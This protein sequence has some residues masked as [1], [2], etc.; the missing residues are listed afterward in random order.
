VPAKSKAQQRFMGM[1]HAYKKGELKGSEASQAIKDAAKG[2]KKKSAKDYASTKHKG[3]PKK[4]KNEIDFGK[5]LQKNVDKYNKRAKKS[6][7]SM[8][9]HADISAL[10]KELSKL[11]KRWVGAQEKMKSAAKRGD[12]KMAN[13]WKGT[14]KK[15]VTNMDKVQDK[16]NAA[17]KKESVSEVF[18]IQYKKD[19]RYLT[20]KELFDKIPQKFDTEKDAK[21]MLSGLD[22]QYRGNYKI[23]KV[24]ESVNEAKLTDDTLA[25]RIKHWAGQHKGTGVGYGHVLGSLAI[26]MK[27]MGWDKSFKEVVK[28]AKELSKKKKVESVNEGKW[29]KIMTSVRKGS[30]AGP[31]SI[32]VYD[33]AKRKVIHNRIVKILQQIPAH[34]EDVKK[35]YPRASIGIE[36]KY[37]HRVYTE[38][39]NEGFTK[40]HI[41]LTN[42]RGWYGVWD[43]NGKQ[44]FEG[45]RRYVTRQLKK[46]KT[47]MGNVQLKSLID[48]ATKRKGKNIEFDVV[49]SVDEGLGDN[50]L[51]NLKKYKKRAGKNKAAMDAARK[52][53]KKESVGEGT[54]G[55]THTVDGKKLK[56]PGGTDDDISEA[57]KMNVKLL[58]VNAKH[59]ARDVMDFYKELR[60]PDTE[61]ESIIQQLDYLKDK[62]KM[63]RKN[64]GLK[65][66]VNE[67][68]KLDL[69]KLYNKALKL[70]AKSPVQMKVR[71][72]IATLRKKIGMDE[73][74]ESG[75]DIARRVVKNKQ[76]EKGLDLTTANFIIQTYKAYNKNPRLQKKLDKMPLLKMVKLA[77][78]VMK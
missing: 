36:D 37:G 45:D 22:Y 44:K 24:K 55:Y 75:I 58:Q 25:S 12:T 28:V 20:S 14:V 33:K 29:S 42:T 35:K 7:A 27:E 2:M 43:K 54:C 64:A 8:K 62:V 48:V 65:E 74:K 19:K 21:N 47:R 51:K 10:R 32:V 46:L 59:F 61:P 4:V 15:A 39:V 18:V 63:M 69:L 66:S 1:V 76:H 60:S 11:E 9:K 6:K 67:D 41:R 17:R 78:L 70:P 5:K 49:E 53:K 16:I 31:W 3:L 57:K 73:A 26:H 50:V 52:R 34:Y 13:K 68:T 23:V 30:K 71:K 56:T 77:H 40:Y 38:S 72:K